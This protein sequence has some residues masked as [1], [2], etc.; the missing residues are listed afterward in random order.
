MHL[1]EVYDVVSSDGVSL[2]QWGETRFE[3]FLRPVSNSLLT[4]VRT[5]G[6]QLSTERVSAFVRPV[7]DNETI[8]GIS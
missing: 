8:G 2:T 5:Y 1:S 6:G 7:V 4:G 3:R